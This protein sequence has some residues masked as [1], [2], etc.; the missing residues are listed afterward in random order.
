ME[1]PAAVAA[2]SRLGSRGPPSGWVQGPSPFSGP[3]LEPGL[4]WNSFE[5]SSEVGVVDTLER[6]EHGCTR[7]QGLPQRQH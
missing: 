3:N 1:R 6:T 5:F 7:P 4:T 2:S